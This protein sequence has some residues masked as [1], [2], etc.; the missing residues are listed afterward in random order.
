MRKIDH[1]FRHREGSR[2]PLDGDHPPDAAHAGHPR[3]NHPAGGGRE[4]VSSAGTPTHNGHHL[5]NMENKI[6]KEG[7]ALSCVV[8]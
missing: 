2:L 1:T 8:F 7:S 3:R 4:G 5:G 6:Q